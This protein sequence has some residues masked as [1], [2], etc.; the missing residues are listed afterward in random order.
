MPTREA[1]EALSTPDVVA[2]FKAEG[3]DPTGVSTRDEMISIMLGETDSPPVVE[4]EPDPEPEVDDD[5][6]LTTRQAGALLAADHDFEMSAKHENAIRDAVARILNHD[7]TLEPTDFEIS[8]ESYEGKSTPIHAVTKISVPGA[9]NCATVVVA[10]EGRRAQCSIN[11]GK[12][13]RRAYHM[14]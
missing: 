9:K 1:L 14:Q 8:T 7:P 3:F 4:P 13:E 2:A 10:A 12:I 6:P 11:H 5:G